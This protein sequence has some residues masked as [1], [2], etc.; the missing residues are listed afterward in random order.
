MRIYFHVNNV[1]LLYVRCKHDRTINYIV[2]FTSFFSH[3]TLNH[4][5]NVHL[6]YALCIDEMTLVCREFTE[7]S[8]WRIY[9]RNGNRRQWGVL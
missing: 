6:Y 5:F 3:E 9:K 8:F 2:N 1:D 7:R 4:C